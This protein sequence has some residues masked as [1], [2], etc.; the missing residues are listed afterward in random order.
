MIDDI[1]QRQKPNQEDRYKETHPEHTVYQKQTQLVQP[2]AKVQPDPR[3]KTKKS[4]SDDVV[5]KPRDDSEREY[6]HK[7]WNHLPLPAFDN[8]SKQ[9]QH[10]V[11][12]THANISP[13]DV[14]VF[15]FVEPVLDVMENSIL[16]ATV[17]S[18]LAHLLSD[19]RNLRDAQ[20]RRSY[21]D[22]WNTTARICTSC[23][24]P[25]TANAEP[26]NSF[27]YYETGA[28][29]NRLNTGRNYMDARHRELQHQIIQPSNHV[30]SLYNLPIHHKLEQLPALNPCENVE[31][32]LEK[33]KRDVCSLTGVPYEMVH[34]KS[35]SGGQ[36]TTGRTN[37]IGRNFSKTVYR[38]CVVL[39]Q[40]VSECYCT[41]YGTKIQDIEVHFNPMPRLDISSIEDVKTLWEMGAVTPD[42]MAQ[43]SEILLLSEST[44]VTGK[45]RKT[46]HSNESYK[47][48]LKDVY[49][50][51]KPPTAVKP[52]TSAK[53][54]TSDKK[55]Q[56]S[57]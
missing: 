42:V 10:V 18:P 23:I 38:M 5:L 2:E 1:R 56:S 46:T 24:P 15:D 31:F 53:N 3:G 49:K 48:N 52:P 51:M 11:E 37:I 12:L 16:C 55:P 33:Y 50:A 29:T 57:K 28:S 19:Y 30:P 22:A 40:L 36:E 13:H 47:Q 25:N 21:A 32:L 9:V 14:F 54:K 45:K 17:P 43:L 4:D 44:N 35:Q 8:A 27:L 41:I 6:V 39:E 34:G 26:T 7:R 20:I